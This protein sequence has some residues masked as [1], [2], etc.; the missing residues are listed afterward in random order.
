MDEKL[1]LSVADRANPLWVRL[2][3]HFNQRIAKLRS[4]NDCDLDA[5]QTAKMRGRISEIKALMS[6]DRDD[7][8]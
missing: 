4:D 5:E 1:K 7:L 3:D 2:M 8:N 6:L